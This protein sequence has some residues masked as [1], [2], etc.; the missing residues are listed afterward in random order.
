MNIL[1]VGVSGFIGK[2]LYYAL[3]QEGHNVRGCSRSKVADIHWQRF[4]FEQTQKQWESLL[5]DIDLVINAV[6]IFE[7]TDNQR[8]SQ[9]HEIGPKILFDACTSLKIKVLQISA[10]GADK[11]HPLTEFLQSKRNADQYLLAQK[12]SNVVLYP[13]IVLGEKGK[14][15]RQL[16]LLACLS[17]IPLIFGRQKE[18]PL[19]SIYQLT[20]Y[21][22]E[23]INGWPGKN[24]TVI[25]IAKP[26]TVENLLNN[27][28]QWM[29]LGKGN[30]IVLPEKIIK[31][32]FYFIPKLSFGAFNKQSLLMLNAY[33][34]YESEKLPTTAAKIKQT[35]SQ[36]LLKQ[37]ATKSF[38][39]E[40]YLKLLFFIN[41]F[42]LGFIWIVSGLSSFIN[43]EMSRELLSM[44]R[45][46]GSLGDMVIYT[47]AVM[48]VLLGL[49]LWLSVWHA[50]LRQWLIYA[51]I[52]VMVIYSLIISIF[53]PIFWLH[54]FAPII[55]NL[56][57]LIMAMYL[58]VETNPKRS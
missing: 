15:S 35:A 56:A 50:R 37:E 36:S 58:L 31:L 12:L 27:L 17:F 10:I 9:T 41:I 3:S 21:I 18:F 57:M 5:K 55:K 1:I 49:L 30:F 53:Q 20:E 14:S 6:G 13:G 19:I 4:S 25:L 47:A 45:I 33:T 32:A 22:K 48:D 38:K 26:E 39:K 40:I 29:G 42:I 8:F 52:L 7:Q 44:I 46:Q 2:H 51:Q 34:F 24:K 11:D 23:V 54:P 43:I 16:S 28:R